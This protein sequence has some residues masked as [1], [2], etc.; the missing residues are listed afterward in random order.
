MENTGYLLRP[1]Q[2]QD[3]KLQRT[4]DS[5]LGQCKPLVPPSET[6][7]KIGMV[8]CCAQVCCTIHSASVKIR[9]NR[10]CRSNVNQ[11]CDVLSMGHIGSI[12]CGF[13]MH[14]LVHLPLR[15]TATPSEAPAQTSCFARQ[16]ALVVNGLFFFF[17]S[18]LCFFYIGFGAGGLFFWRIVQICAFH[19][20]RVLF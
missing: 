4:D 2:A 13:E 19:A 6:I 14:A 3:G 7:L 11:R 20:L 12:T 15:S 10:I 18:T 9:Y 5:F 16:K 17:F 1:Q 8:G